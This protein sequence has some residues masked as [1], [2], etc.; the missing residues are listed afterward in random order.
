MDIYDAV[1]EY[2][3]N[4]KDSREFSDT[5]SPENENGRIISFRGDKI[6]YI[7]PSRF[8]C[9]TEKDAE[10]LHLIKQNSPLVE[11]DY[12]SMKYNHMLRAKLNSKYET[13]VYTLLEKLIALHS[14]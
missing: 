1:K 4:H 7:S 3:A 5:R 6:M 10:R 8:L 12:K 13:G 11:W 2:I 9:I 14:F